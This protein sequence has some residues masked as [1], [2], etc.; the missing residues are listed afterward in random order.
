MRRLNYRRSIELRRCAAALFHI[1][2][3]LAV[4]LRTLYRR[5]VKA[6]YRH[7]NGGCKLKDAVYYRQMYA[8]VT[9]NALFAYIF[10]ARLELRLD[11]KSVV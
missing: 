5:I 2:K 9:N 11:R 1:A 3:V 4:A 10:P 8:L 6:H 7:A